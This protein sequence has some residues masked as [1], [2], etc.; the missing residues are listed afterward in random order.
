MLPDLGF[1]KSSALRTNERLGIAIN[2]LGGKT[3]APTR[4]QHSRFP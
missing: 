2:H 1:A 3:S 4:R